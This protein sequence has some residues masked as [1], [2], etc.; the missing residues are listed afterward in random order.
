[1]S[2]KQETEKA[3]KDIKQKSENISKPTAKKSNKKSKEV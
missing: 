2:K 1:M 3:D